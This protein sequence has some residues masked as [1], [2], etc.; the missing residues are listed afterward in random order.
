MSTI[1][2]SPSISW[3][4]SAV[5]AVTAKFITFEGIDGAGKSSH[6]EFV[7]DCLRGK[8]IDVVT[9]REP[10]GT[11]FCEAIRHLVLNET[12]HA[13]TEALLLF[14]SRREQLATVIEPA[15]AR[16]VWVIC[17]RFTDS[18]YAY[19]CGGRG[20]DEARIAALEQFVHGDRQPDLTLLFDAPVETARERLDKNSGQQDKF[21]RE[22]GEFFGRV[23]HAYLAR[24]ATFPQRI[25]VLDS[26]RTI[27][28][29]RAD[30]RRHLDALSG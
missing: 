29:I 18:T 6:I 26:S 5:P 30:I 19:Q 22:R 21:E 28:A 13:D 27:D 2:L 4:A 12:M 23:R 1:G 3:G 25:K 10:G 7:A 11:T 8:S 24:A 9:T 17:D 14:A 20:V 15:L 16:G